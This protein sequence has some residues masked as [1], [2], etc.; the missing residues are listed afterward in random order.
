M[1]SSVF[2]NEDKENFMVNEEEK[3]DKNSKVNRNGYYLRNSR[4]TVG[5]NPLKI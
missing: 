5:I 1:M 2:I 3:I 4:Y